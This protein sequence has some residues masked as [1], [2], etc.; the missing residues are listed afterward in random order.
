MIP[1][2]KPA[3]TWPFGKRG[4]PR[5]DV[6]LGKAT[7]KLRGYLHWGW[8]FSSA[9]S[10]GLPLHVSLCFA[11]TRVQ[12]QPSAL[13]LPR[14]PGVTSSF[15]TRS[16]ATCVWRYPRLQIQPSLWRKEGLPHWPFPQDAQTQGALIKFLTFLPKLFLL[17][18]SFLRAR[19][20]SFKPGKTLNAH[21]SDGPLPPSPFLLSDEIRIDLVLS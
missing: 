15:P 17:P 10:G 7:F 4:A 13:H 1:G 12:A 11:F 18:C 6:S 5:Y 19:P 2:L 20:V 21:P 8:R 14:S 3:Q 9:V 16:A